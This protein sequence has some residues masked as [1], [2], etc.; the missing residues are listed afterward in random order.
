[1]ANEGNL[2]NWK[3]GQSGNP[4]GSS[5][6]MLFTAA[7]KRKL[8]TAPRKLTD[9]FVEAGYQAA[10]GGDFQFWRYLYERI[11]GPMPKDEPEP[12]L[13]AEAIA[14]M[15]SVDARLDECESED[16]QEAPGQVPE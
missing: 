2:K 8:R 11:D 3:P 7:L 12:E 9:E 15:E 14:E 6:K 1:M 4:R 10:L 13:T 16:A 5:K